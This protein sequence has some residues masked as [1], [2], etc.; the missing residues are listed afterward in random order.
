[1]KNSNQMKFN[2]KYIEH[3]VYKRLM[4]SGPKRILSLDGGGIRGAVSLGYLLEIETLLRERYGRNDLVLSD[5]FDLIGGTSTGSIIAT[6]LALGKSVE[7]IKRVYFNLG[8][9]IFLK[10]KHILNWW[11]FKYFL[12]AEYDHSKLEA[13]LDEYLGNI[14]LGSEELRTGLAIFTKRAD[15]MSIYNFHNHPMNSYYES[16][17]GIYLRDLIRASSA[18]PSYFAPKEI[19]FPDGE[20]AIFVDGG[21]SMVNNPGLMLFLMVTIKGYGY[22]WG[23]GKDNLQ[24]ISVGTGYSN[25]KV[26]G[27][28]KAAILNRK[29]V[30]WASE[31]SDIFMSDAAEQN[32]LLLQFFSNP[33]L[34]EQVNKEAGDLSGDLISEKPLLDYCRYNVWLEQNTLT[35][36]GFHF[37]E[38][39]VEHLQKMENGDNVNELFD[40]GLKDAKNKVASSHFSNVFDFGLQDKKDLFISQVDAINL[41]KPF[42][43]SNGK[44]YKKHSKILAYEAVA[45]E[46]IISITT[47]GIETKND[48][49]PGDFV[50]QNDTTSKEQYVIKKEDFAGLYEYCRDIDELWKEYIPKGRVRGIQLDGR[51]KKELKLPH[52]FHIIASWGVGMYITEGDFIVM[53][54]GKEE[55]YRIGKPEFEST[56]V[57]AQD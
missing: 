4:A 51:I 13:E 15:T 34:P 26:Q 47:D 40:I 3:P 19:K 22:G 39:R 5:Y 37:N 35:N 36:L 50:V 31:L 2:Q 27:K 6:M 42:I 38:S 49:R 43:L 57:L 54:T 30:S 20:S 12:K 23:K 55:V 32:Q 24:L 56:Y 53:P 1:M 33:H 29:T 10:R 46:E 17:K 48:A 7:E 11:Y 41:F 21:V 8:K 14:T 25:Q 16:N 28:K 44:D 45:L 9:K 52:H 18:A